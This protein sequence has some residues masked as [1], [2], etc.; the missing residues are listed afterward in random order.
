MRIVYALLLAVPV[1]GLAQAPPSLSSA[2]QE[3]IEMGEAY[4]DSTTRFV[5]PIVPSTGTRWFRHWH[6]KTFQTIG[7]GAPNALTAS[8]GR[9]DTLATPGAKF[10]GI[11]FSGLV[12]PD[13]SIGVG[14]A[15]IVQVVNTEIAFFTK[16]G[17]PEFQQSLDGNGFFAGVAETDFVFDPRAVYDQGAKRFIVIALEQ[18]DFPPNSAV[19]LAVSDDSNPHGT[20]YKYRIPTVINRGGQLYWWDYP[21]LAYNKDGIVITGN[22]FSFTSSSAFGRSIS[23]D[24]TPLL[25]GSTAQGYG[26]FHD[27]YFTIQAARTS[28]G[29]SSTIY[30]ISLASTTRMR[31][32]SWRNLKGVPIMTQGDLAVPAYL[33]FNGFVQSP[34]GT[35]IDAIGD[36]MMDASYRSGKLV[37]A[38]TVRVSNSQNRSMVRWYEVRFGSWPLSGSPRLH[39]SGN[40]ALSGTNNLLMPAIAE[41]GKGSISLVMTRSSGTVNPGIF[42]CSRALLDPLG[43]MGPLRHVVTSANSP[44]SANSRWGDYFD[45]VIDPGDSAK[46]W[47]TG[48]YLQANRAWTTE[49]F[50]WSVN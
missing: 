28:E 47:G 8:S 40:V 35:S 32:F 7:T 16:G 41:N 20:W 2:P 18:R 14:P 6:P 9:S 43:T 25:T 4:V 19:L 46:L 48:E 17:T 27:G 13:P 45:V 50:S 1:I 49:I 29:V 44:N 11:S 31:L 42:Y 12:P 30:G 24:K 21:T 38:H 23:I 22:M 3:T 37:C 26:W 34:G 33:V 39:Q 5:K 10:P 36:R 15:H